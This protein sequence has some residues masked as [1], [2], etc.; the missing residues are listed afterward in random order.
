[1]KIQAQKWGNS[2]AVRIP[3][4]F[5]EHIHIQDDAGLE[6]NLEGERLVISRARGRI[7]DEELIAR[8]T[9]ENLHEPVEFGAPV[10]NEAI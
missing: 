5:A 8:I 3:K 4:A 1:M 9:P 6:I 7:D 10:G 2:W